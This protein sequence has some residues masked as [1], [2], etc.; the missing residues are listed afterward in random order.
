M[1]RSRDRA[2]L[3]LTPPMDRPSRASP[4]N[5]AS[6]RRSPATSSSAVAVMRNLAVHGPRREISISRSDTLTP[7]P[8][9]SRT[10]LFQFGWRAPRSKVADPSLNEA[11]GSPP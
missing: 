2:S 8:S 5:E 1:T 9:V 7:K 6:L 10:A 3:C 11:S 4:W